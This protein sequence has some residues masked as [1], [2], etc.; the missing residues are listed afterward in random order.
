LCSQSKAGKTQIKFPK[1]KWKW[2]TMN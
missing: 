2:I 1:P